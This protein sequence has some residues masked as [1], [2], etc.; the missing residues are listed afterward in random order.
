[1]DKPIGI[2]NKYA[3]GFKIEKYANYT[4]VSVF[5]PWQ[6]AEGVEYKYILGK[7]KNLVPDSLKKFDFI[8]LPVKKVVCLSTTHLA[9]LKE[10]GK[11]DVICGVSAPEFIYD[12]AIRKKVDQ[13]KIGNV[14]YDQAINMETI[15]SL[16]PDFVM[17]YGVG[18]E[19]S[20]QFQRL[21]QLGIK[22]VL[23]A[24]YLERTPLGKAEWLKFVG[25]FFGLED[26]A[27][28]IFNQ[29]EQ[30]YLNLKN[31]AN[32]VENEKPFV[33]SGLPWKG[34]WYVPGGKSYA[35]NFIYDAGGDY[36]WK[37]D[38]GTESLALS[39][40]TVMERAGKADIWINPGSVFS[41]NEITA[42][43]S[44]MKR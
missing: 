24:E 32:T 38:T 34:V 42:M 1:M 17:A 23:N 37:E 35:S 16:K 13:G 21:K 28:A 30:S 10:L 22:V 33:L 41:M 19:V 12:A 36:L 2:E 14:G 18:S 29:T 8:S 43:D 40:E 15:L 20:G 27:T 7:D 11:E 3:E 6:H 26:S 4:I 31:I 44:R 39:L 5:N 25:A 9:F